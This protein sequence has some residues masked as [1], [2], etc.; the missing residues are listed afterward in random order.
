[1]SGDDT[2]ER[3]RLWAFANGEV[4][5]WISRRE[6]DPVTRRI[7]FRQEV[8]QEPVASMGGEWSMRP[9]PDG[10]THIVLKHDYS[11][12][13]PAKLDW[14][15]KA[16]DR[17]S[18]SELAA[19]KAVIDGRFEENGLVFSFEDSLDI[20]GP[21][22]DVYDFIYRCQDWPARLPHVS[23][24]HL[25]EDVP[26]IQIMEMDTRAPDGDVHTT[27]S[28]RICF[29]AHRIVYKQIQ[30]PAILSA[31][32]G[33]WTFVENAGVVRATSRHTA[34]IKPDAVTTVL[35]PDATV[36][37]A[38]ERVRTALGTNSMSTLKLAKAH[39]EDGADA[40]RLPAA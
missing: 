40:G 12:V 4:K 18:G 29:P 8:S 25:E 9:A 15:R 14:V 17:N 22:A 3:I 1:M 13:H 36:S 38:R 35:G 37:L 21:L 30:V 23:R 20:A 39:V 6:L 26:N 27:R 31:H 34:V 10:G 11:A 28:V 19:V 7:A 16:V 32:T 2:D 24:L 33:E 5:S